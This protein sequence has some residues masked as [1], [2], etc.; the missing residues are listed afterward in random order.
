MTLQLFPRNA[1]SIRGMASFTVPPSA[2]MA[3]VA[4]EKLARRARAAGADTATT[5][6]APG[7]STVLSS[8]SDGDDDGLED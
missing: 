5:K 6:D 7:S 3:L 2:R 1:Y 4:K 8:N